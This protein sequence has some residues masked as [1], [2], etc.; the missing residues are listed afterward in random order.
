M[1]SLA[2][3]SSIRAHDSIESL[4]RDASSYDLLDDDGFSILLKRAQHHFGLSDGDLA[5]EFLVSRP[6]V[7]R[8]INGRNLPHRVMRKPITEWIAAEAARW[9]RVRSGR[10]TVILA[11]ER[12]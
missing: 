12:V 7:N 6:T 10:R 11:D 9:L 3:S 5:D 4:H 8:W 2:E 1:P